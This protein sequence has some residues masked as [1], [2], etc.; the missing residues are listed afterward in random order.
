[1]F[2]YMCKVTRVVDGDTVDVTIDLGFKLAKS[3]RVRLTG[4]D[5]PES[6]TR[7]LA[8]KKLGLEA[9]A[10][11]K[12]WC[13][14]HKGDIIIHTE[15]EGKYGRLLGALYWGGSEKSVNDLMLEAGFAWEY[16]GGKKEKSFEEL[17][18]RRAAYERRRRASSSSGLMRRV[19]DA[20]SS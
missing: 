8:E 6:R 5:T 9:K 12:A 13:A 14:E 17:A 2:D 16:G 4:I 3:D 10:F 19:I 1:M 20:T 11:L 7:N 18:E 15:S